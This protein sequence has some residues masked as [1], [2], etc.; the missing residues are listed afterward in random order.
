MEASNVRIGLDCNNAHVQPTGKYHYHGSP[1]LY[2][3]NLNVPDDKMTLVGYS[4]DGFPIYHKYAFEI[5]SDWNSSL[6]EM[7]PSYQLKSGNRPGDGIFAP[8]DVYNGV[9]SNDYEYI[10]GLGTLDE[11]NG[12]TRITPEYLDGTYYYVLTDDFPNI[13]RYFRGT[14]S[15]D[16][17]SGM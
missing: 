3:E 14:P 1:T 4:A 2:F 16:F 17:K 9:Y 7:T 11:A 13:P 5:A 10:E 15:Q 6:I 12:R 8:C